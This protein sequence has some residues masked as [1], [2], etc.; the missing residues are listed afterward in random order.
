MAELLMSIHGSALADAELAT[1]IEGVMCNICMRAPTY[2][3]DLVQQAGAL[4]SNSQ[5]PSVARQ[6]HVLSLIDVPQGTGLSAT[7]P[8]EGILNWSTC[9]TS[10]TR[11]RVLQRGPIFS[12]GN[13]L[14][15]FQW[16][17]LSRA[18]L[19]ILRVY[20]SPLLECTVTGQSGMLLA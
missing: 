10:Q 13:M 7:K 17:I 14:K 9:L 19:S 12:L 11:L 20:L 18:Y 3:A 1:A 8:G 6:L 15:A 4:F 16:T 5:Q 2:A